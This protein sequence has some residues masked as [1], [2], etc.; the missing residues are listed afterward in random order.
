M[1]NVNCNAM[2]IDA[3]TTLM[4]CI[5]IDGKEI[6]PQALHNE[7]V[8]KGVITGWTNVEPKRLQALNETIFLA[9]FAAGILAEEIGIA[10][11][12]FD[13]WLGKPIVITCSEVTAV[14]LPHVLECGQHI[15]RADLVVFNPKTDDLHSVSLQ[16]IPNEPCS[17]MV[18]PAPL[19][20]IGQPLLNTIPGIPGF[21]GTEREK[22]TVRFEQWYHAILDAHRNFSEP[23]VTAAITKSCVGEAADAMCCL[24]PEVI[25]DDILET[26]KWLYG[27]V[28]SSDT[29]MQEFYHIVQ[30]KSEKVQTFV[31]HL[32][33]ALKAIRQQYPYA[34]T[35]EEGH[36]HLKDHLFHGLKPNLHNGLCH[37]HDKPDSQYSQ[38]VMASR[39]AG[40]ETLG[41][42]VSKGRA[43]SAIV[44][45]NTDLAESKASSEPSY[46]A[47][48]QQIVYL[49]SAVANQVMPE[50][51]KPSGHPGFKPNETNKYSSNMLQRPK[52]DQKNMTCWGCGG[53]RH[54]WRECSTPRQENTLPFRPNLP[55]AN[56][57]KRQNLN[58]QQGEENQSFNPL[59]VTTR[60]ESTSTRN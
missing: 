46:E 37:L 28:E 51:T 16:T 26:F 43:K 29:L 4:V 23:L 50:L 11:E 15:S 1:A 21:P 7:E 10:I 39:K 49:M 17:L 9:T 60:E 25:L 59:P 27:S 12:K 56:P 41:S 58:G 35:E 30:G 36:R 6:L 3:N 45:T 20:P 34:V 55:N 24:P 13:N 14:K 42:G 32:E 31:L 19:K 22:D 2:P 8:A 18:S 52:H 47:I 48:T 40:T 38:L 57:G 5:L 53:T 54:S 44:G 33:S